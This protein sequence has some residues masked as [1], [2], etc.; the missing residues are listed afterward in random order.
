MI[1][2]EGFYWVQRG[3]EEP[4]IWFFSISEDGA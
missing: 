1:M 3:D 4:E 2:Q